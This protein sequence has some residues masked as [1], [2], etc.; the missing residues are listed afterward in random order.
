[1]LCFPSKSC[2]CSVEFPFSFPNLCIALCQVSPLSHVPALSLPAAASAAC[3]ALLPAFTLF[4][5]PGITFLSKCNKPSPAPL[6]TIWTST[7]SPD[8]NHMPL[9]LFWSVGGCF[10]QFGQDPAPTEIKEKN[11]YWFHGSDWKFHRMLSSC[12]I[13]AA[14]WAHLEFWM[15]AMIITKLWWYNTRQRGK[16]GFAIS[17]GQH[18]IAVKWFI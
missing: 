3:A 15:P 11:S 1:M 18:E 17:E 9:D 14:H 7:C 12:F 13:A 6:Q 4:Q 8:S 10:V 2:T 16:A 5:L